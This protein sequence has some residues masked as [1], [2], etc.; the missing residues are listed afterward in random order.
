MRNGHLL[1]LAASCLALINDAA[2]AP[3]DSIKIEGDSAIF[4]QD[5]NTITYSGSVRATLGDLSISGNTLVV[6]LINDQADK[7]QTTGSP[8]R[9][10]KQTTATA[11]S[12]QDSLVASA[13]SIMFMPSSQQL[14]LKGNATLQQAGSTIKSEQILYDVDARQ[15]RADGKQDRVRMEFDVVNTPITKEP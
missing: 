8:A 3:S 14:E 12:A 1:L 6:T 5:A 7:I 13:T 10:L 2:A 11:K 9:L 4:D 15:V